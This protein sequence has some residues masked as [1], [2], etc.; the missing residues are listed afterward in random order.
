MEI[1]EDVG[2][3]PWPV[4]AAPW[5]LRQSWHDLM[6]A[7]WPVARDRLR[8]LVPSF[9]EIDTFDTEAWLGIV[10]FHL[11][12]LSPRGVPALPWISSFNEINV[13]TCVVHDGIPG[14]YFFS[15]D[16]NSAVAV[17]GATTLFHLPYFLADIRLE[18]ERGRIVY[19]SRRKSSTAEFEAQYAPAGRVFEPV[20]GTLEYWLTERYCLYAQDTASKTYRVEIHH[21]PW[22]LQAAEAQIP[23]NSMADAAGI[24]L[25]SMV[26]LLH[27]ARRQDV[28]TWSPE[29]LR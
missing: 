19:S 10:P 1:L 26:P 27:F 25:P 29:A 13:R 11:S 2:H 14:V 3:R 21:R 5:I 8:E 6:F 7:H 4:P 18:E 22:Q 23:V 15:L 17:A 20:P 16:A 28:L 12:D 24:R 9:L